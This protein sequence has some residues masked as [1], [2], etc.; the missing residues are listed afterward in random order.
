MIP[1]TCAAFDKLG[2]ELLIDE[3]EEMELLLLSDFVVFMEFMNSRC[4][5]KHRVWCKTMI[6]INRGAINYKILINDDP[7][8]PVTKNGFLFQEI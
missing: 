4:G 6:K 2:Y 8:I 1:T 7:C 5:I 3:R